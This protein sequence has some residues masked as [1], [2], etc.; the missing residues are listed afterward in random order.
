MSTTRFSTVRAA[1]EYLAG[2]I[3]EQAEREGSPLTELERKMLYF[4]ETDWTLPDMMK[5]SEEFDRDYDQDEY[6]EKIRGLVS[7]LLA[8]EDQQAVEA[9]DEAVVKISDG[10]HYL[11]VLISNTPS[12]PMELPGLLRKLG[13]W[14]P[15][16]NAPI[17]RRPGDRVRLI[18]SA[19]AILALPFLFRLLLDRVF[20]PDWYGNMA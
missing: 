6:E 4:S 19:F 14:L 8:A 12:N 20:G 7:R 18:V 15:D 16:L 2:R 5:V 11:Q 10:D 17:P 13:P 3:S 1:K 9:W